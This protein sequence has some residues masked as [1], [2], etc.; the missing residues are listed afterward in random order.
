[1][2]RA[3][4][5]VV[6]VAIIK[7]ADGKMDSERVKVCAVYDSNHE[8]ENGKWSKWT[9][10]ANLDIQINNPDAM[11]KLSSGHEYFVDFTP[12][13]PAE[14]RTQQKESSEG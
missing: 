14:F 7:S 9:P 4:M 2:L 13:P 1:M 3:K 8:S 5:R 12:V 10:R 11:G 6:E